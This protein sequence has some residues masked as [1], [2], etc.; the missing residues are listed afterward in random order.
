MHAYRQMGIQLGRQIYRV[1]V[2][3]KCIV[4]VNLQK[5]LSAHKSHGTSGRPA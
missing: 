4:Y 2:R 5:L 1:N 3:V